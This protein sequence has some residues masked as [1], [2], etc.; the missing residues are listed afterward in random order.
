MRIENIILNIL[1]VLPKS[2]LRLIAGPPVI[3]DGNELDINIQIAEKLSEKEMK[4]KRVTTHDYREAAKQFDLA[5][6]PRVRG[7]GIEDIKIQGPIEELKA[8][9]YFPKKISD[10]NGAILFFHQGG[11]V[12]MNHLTDDYFCSLLSDVC[13]AKVISLD[14]RLCPENEFPTPIEDCLFLWDYVQKNFS[15]LGVDPH[16]VALAGDSAGGMISS[17]MSI[18]LR[19]RKEVQPLA[20]CV[21]YPWVTS[22]MNDQPSIESCADTFPMSRETMEFFNKNVFPN[23]RN[24][25]HPWANPLNKNDLSNLPPTIIAT[26]GFDPIRDQGQYF[27]KKL[28]EAKNEVKHLYFSNLSHSFLILG[29]ISKKANEASIKLAYELSKYFE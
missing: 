2:F 18:I 17:T 21:A 29:R 22:S 3:I 20:M 23:G 25:D 16:K 12:L 26:A 7:I 10:K 4:K 6:L 28:V 13:N 24:L 19:D 14:Y 27:A 1:R 11:F 5:G 8:R 9:I 15:K